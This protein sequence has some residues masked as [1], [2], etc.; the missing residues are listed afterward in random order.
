[1]SDQSRTSVRVRISPP[2]DLRREASAATI[3]PD[4][5]V[6]NG[7]PTACAAAPRVRATPAVAIRGAAPQR[8]H[9]DRRPGAARIGLEASRDPRS[10]L[11]REAPEPCPRERMSECG[12]RGTERE[13]HRVLP[14]AGDTPERTPVGVAVCSKSL[15]GCCGVAEQHCSPTSVQRVRHGDRR[16]RPGKVGERQRDKRRRR[17]GQWVNRRTDVVVKTRQRELRRSGSASDRCSSLEHQNPLPR[18]SKRH[19][20]NEPIR[21]RTND[22]GVEHKT[23][24]R[25]EPSV[26]SHQP[27]QERAGQTAISGWC[28]EPGAWCLTSRVAISERGSY[29]SRLG[30]SSHPCWRGDLLRR[31]PVCVQ[32]DE[33][34]RD[35]MVRRLRRCCLASGPRGVDRG[36]VRPRIRRCSRPPAEDE[37]HDWRNSGGDHP[38][39][40]C[41]CDHHVDRVRAAFARLPAAPRSASSFLIPSGGGSSLRRWTEVLGCSFS[42]RSFW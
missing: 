31:V 33:P 29:R 17:S 24:L 40:R 6:A 7:Q 11:Q 15:G 4:P 28:L 36:S 5:P 1:M 2:S 16:L 26:I 3:E 9:R 10:G 38:H 25:L 27:D 37:P 39:G 12:E 21:P 13:P 8:E 19:R 20:S 41:R 23:S 32:P 35:R 30:A 42:P 34:A 22:D 18:G 14:M